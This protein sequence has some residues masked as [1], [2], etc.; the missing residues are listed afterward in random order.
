[1]VDQTQ[2][3]KVRKPA[4]EFEAM[5]W[6]NGFKKVKLSDYKGIP[7]PTLILLLSL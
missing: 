5:A 3:A 1:M 7:N 2:V 4:P 6:F